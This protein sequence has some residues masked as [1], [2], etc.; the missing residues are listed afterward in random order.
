MALNV[1][2]VFLVPEIPVLMYIIICAKSTKKS[3]ADLECPS[4]W[5]VLYSDYGVIVLQGG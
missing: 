1:R 5:S 2:G 4:V 3:C